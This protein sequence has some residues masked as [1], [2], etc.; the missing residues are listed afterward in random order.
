MLT[1]LQVF[2]FRGVCTTA[3]TKYKQKEIE[4]QKSTSIE[5][6]INRKKRGSSHIRKIL[7]K[8][9]VSGSTRN[10]N[11]FARNMDIIIS[12]EQSKILNS[13]W[14]KNYFSNQD[15]TFFSNCTTTS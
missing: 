2:R 9:L 5:T 13:F 10:I 7:G 15:R 14:A 12:G 6:F 3:K 11:K 8:Q 1:E 4:L